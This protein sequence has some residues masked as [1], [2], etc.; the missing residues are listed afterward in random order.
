MSDTFIRGKGN[1]LDVIHEIDPEIT[2]EYQRLRGDDP[3]ILEKA[4]KT[5][6]QSQAKEFLVRSDATCE[7]YF[8]EKRVATFAGMFGTFPF[9]SWRLSTPG[10]LESV[11]HEISDVHDFA[12][13]NPEKMQAVIDHLVHV[14]SREKQLM[15]KAPKKAV[16]TEEYGLKLSE[17]KLL[18]NRLRNLIVPGATGEKYLRRLKKAAESLYICD[19]RQAVAVSEIPFRAQYIEEYARFRSIDMSD[20]RMDFILHQ[21]YPGRQ[22][23]ISEHPNIGEL[24]HYEKSYYNLSLGETWR[25]R[26]VFLDE[27]KHR[28]DDV[29]FLLTAFVDIL[30]QLRKDRVIPEDVAYVAECL[31]ES[32]KIVQL[33][34]YFMKEPGKGN[35]K[36]IGN[37]PEEGLLFEWDD[38]EERYISLLEIRSITNPAASVYGTLPFDVENNEQIRLILNDQHRHNCFLSHTGLRNLEAAMT[39]DNSCTSYKDLVDLCGPEKVRYFEKPDGSRTFETIE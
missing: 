11:F 8:D 3:E 29:E 21:K 2:G 36:V 4:R 33:R 38:D 35:K 5:I 34:P 39:Y 18:L 31:D 27:I 19:G 13:L 14:L 32:R 17:R 16:I 7:D 30:T 9:K 12:T 20:S 1:L 26:D 22:I 25:S 10:Y 24:F 6:R 15:K 28:R 37:I 23:L